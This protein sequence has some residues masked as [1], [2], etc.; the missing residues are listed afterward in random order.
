M[1]VCVC[2]YCLGADKEC[3]GKRAEGDLAHLQTHEA[4]E[5]DRPLQ[6][7]QTPAEVPPGHTSVRPHLTRTHAYTHTLVHISTWTQQCC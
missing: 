6:S 7:P 4:D 2:I 1:H 5:E 3:G